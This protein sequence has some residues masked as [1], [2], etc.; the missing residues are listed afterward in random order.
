MNKE[1]KLWAFPALFCGL[2]L[3][4]VTAMA[5]PAVIWYSEPVRPGEAVMV[6]GGPWKNISKIELNGPGSK[7]VAPLRVTND[8][9]TFVYPE[10]WPLAAFNAKITEQGSKPVSIKVN[11]PDAWWLQGDNG[12]EATPGGWLRI[13]GRCIGYK[14]KASVELRGDGRMITLR[15]AEADL[16]SCKALL[17]KNIAAGTYSVYLK[18]GLDPVPVNAGEIRIAPKKSFWKEK[19]FNIADYGAKPN[20]LMDDSR[21]INAALADI[22]KNKGGILYIPRGRFGIQ[23]EL[24][25]PPHT[26]LRGAGMTLTQLYWM[27]M[28]FPDGSLITGT[29]DFG[30]ENIF[31]VSGNL[32]EGITAVKPVKGDKWKNEN[33]VLYRV[34][35]S[36]LHTDPITKKEGLRRFIQKA[37]NLNINAVNVR[38]TECD[39]I[40]TKGGFGIHGD[41]LYVANN[42]FGGAPSNQCFWL[43]GKRIIFENNDCKGTGASL[44]NNTW[45][46][47]LHKNI[48]GG[49]FGDGDR[50]TFT[51]DGGGGTY[52]KKIE[53]TDG[54][55]VKL[56]RFGWRHGRKHWIGKS[57]YIIGGRGAGQMREITE[58]GKNKVTVDRPWDILPDKTSHFVI[59]NARYKLLYIDNKVLDGNPFQLYGSAIEVIEAKNRLY[60]NGG[61]PAYGMCKG[62]MPEPNWFVQFLDNKI[63]EGN[64]VRGPWSY[65]I[66]A[67]DSYLAFFDRG[68]RKPLTY[69]QARVGIIR[70]NRLLSNAYIYVGRRVIDALVE[71]NLVENADRGIVAGTPTAILRGNRFK[72]VVE[73]YQVNPGALTDPAASLLGAL[74]AAPATLGKDIPKDWDKFTAKAEA[75]A[76]K[77]IP[78]AEKAKFRAKI[79][80]AALKSLSAKIGS[81][82]IPAATVTAM[83]GLDLS[84]KTPWMLSRVRRGGKCKIPIGVN[85]PAWGIPAK[86]TAKV[87]GFK[88]WD[89][90]MKCPKQLVPGSKARC[91]LYVTPAKGATPPYIL[92]VEYQISG[93]GWKFNFSEKYAD[94]TM[95]VTQFLVAGPFRNTSGEDRDANVHPPEIDLNVSASYDTTEGKRP[96]FPVK[97]DK[98]GRID[99]NKVL[100]KAEMSTVHAVAIVRAKKPVQ[101]QVKYPRNSKTFLFVNGERVGSSQRREGVRCVYLKKGDNLFHLI[102]SHGSGKWPLDTTLTVV[103][104]VGPGDLRIVDT[105]ELFKSPL[106]LPKGGKI[107]EGKDIPNSLGIDW[108]LIYSDS[109]NRTRVGTGWKCKSPGW[110]SQ[111]PAIVGN[112][113]VSEAGWGFL[114]YEQP[115][116]VPVRIEFDMV[117]QINMAGVILCPEGLSWRSFWGRGSSGQQGRGYCMTIGWHNQRDNRIIRDNEIVVVDKK[118]PVLNEGKKYHITGQF[119]PPYCQLY[120]DGKLYMQY[121]DQK[122]LTGLDRIGIFQLGK[123]TFDNIRIY[124][125]KK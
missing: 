42:H 5:K 29:H 97:A 98:R 101:V 60:R 38:V 19:V 92:P 3:C 28:D 104:P 40:A 39:F 25:L 6:F 43:G 8:C 48:L 58:I 88:G 76:K 83:T 111:K 73:P 105:E 45:F 119:V 106:L 51:F 113:L 81:K 2:I 57:I 12:K 17:P 32:N 87:K 99:L 118:T 21:A 80:D 16:Y 18:N 70:R 49:I 4:G 23:G 85:Y 10:N 108:K 36:F 20:D 77:S 123:A 79:L 7:S 47:Y 55:T 22:V 107:P 109:F 35:T 66:P 50:E 61:C 86:L 56:K 103:D 53:G 90:S 72:N 63:M 30:I 9:V 44:S 11:T 34:R 69:S 67:N 62:G 75:L 41:Y 64:A 121:K 124:Q 27:D 14:S 102:S 95:P 33:I 82:S 120:V 68:I 65:L 117:Y 122:F 31:L 78:D 52:N 59:A 24:K 125:Q 94:N 46:L 54:L 96:W 15:S 112:K 37:K 1:K 13:L 89:V 93:N 71:N 26:L 74:Q 115:V 114:T 110:M 91:E 116:T 84:Q 100:K